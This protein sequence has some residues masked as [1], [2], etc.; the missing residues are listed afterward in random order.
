MARL[1]RLLPGLRLDLRDPAPRVLAELF[2]EPVDSI[3]LEIGFGGGEHLA[4]QAG[5]HPRTGFIGI[6]PFVNGV[7][8]L[9]QHVEDGKLKNIRIFDQ[10]A[11]PVL[12]WLPAASIAQAFILFPDPWPK[13]RHRKR[14]L[15][16]PRTLG[17]LARVLMPG[18]ELRIATDIADYALGTLLALQATPELTWTARSARDWRERSADWPE[19]RYERKA[20]EAARRCTYFRFRRV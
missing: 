19:T 2:G 9:L 12:D 11:G 15:V 10:E 17:R 8:S 18:A 7:S 16:S 6:E 4:F 1:E 20:V 5:A 14:R 3:A 13:T